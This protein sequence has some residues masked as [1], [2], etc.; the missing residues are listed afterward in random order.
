M[1]DIPIKRCPTC[2]QQWST[3]DEFLDDP[4]VGILKYLANFDVLECGLLYF[5]HETC[6]SVLGLCVSDFQHL[7]RSLTFSENKAGKEGCPGYCLIEKEFSPCKNTCECR[8]VRDVIQII[9]NWKKTDHPENLYT[10]I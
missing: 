1:L 4:T 6:S 5:N 7:R 10:I 3:A 9:K 2:L 8:W